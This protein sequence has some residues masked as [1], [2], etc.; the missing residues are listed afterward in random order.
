MLAFDGNYRFSAPRQQ[1]WA[2]LNDPEVLQGTIPGCQNLT[3]TGEETFAADL[4]LKFGPLRFTTQGSLC[5]VVEE[6][7]RAYRLE[8]ASAK[9]LLGSGQGKAWVR[10]CDVPGGGTDL[11]YRVEA[12][13][14]GRLA[15]LGASLVAGQLQ[16]LGT[17]FFG[18][19]EKV[20]QE[21]SHA[22]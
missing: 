16:A 13:M 7:A 1:V 20:M 22:V 21:K 18:R 4:Q 9:T 5:V 14:T 8:G 19:F 11:H 3:K 10:L 15:K 17:G 12:Q 6:A 2:A